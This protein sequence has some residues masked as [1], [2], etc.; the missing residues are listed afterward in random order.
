MSIKDSTIKN[1]CTFHFCLSFSM[2]PPY[3]RWNA[4]LMSL[5]L[6]VVCSPILIVKQ[7]L[8]LEQP[9]Y[10]SATSGY[11]PYNNSL[12]DVMSHYKGFIVIIVKIS[13]TNPS[14]D[15]LPMATSRQEGL[16]VTKMY[17]QVSIPVVT[18]IEHDLLSYITYRCEDILPE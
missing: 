4:L 5:L 9:R 8:F 2:L 10:Q 13:V 6:W 3:C 1:E 11:D 16:I 12:P 7:L 17:S 18:N 15:S 14:Y